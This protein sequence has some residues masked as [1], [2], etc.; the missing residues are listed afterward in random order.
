MAK[1][2]ELQFDPLNSNRGTARGRGMIEDSIQK[3]GAGRSILLD[4]NNMIIAG[5]KTAEVA[6]AAGLDVRIIETDGRELIAVKRTDMDLM[7]DPAARALAIADNRTAEV[8][9]EWN[10]EEITKAQNAGVDLTDFFTQE[11]LTEIDG[12]CREVLSEKEKKLVPYK[13]VHVLIS[14]DIDKLHD[15]GSLIDQLRKID[16]VEIETKAN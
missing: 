15:V 5:N 14:M 4:K 7:K 13:K 10:P 12:E 8:D 3:L 2:K 11:E 1:I 6:G 16:G 9:L